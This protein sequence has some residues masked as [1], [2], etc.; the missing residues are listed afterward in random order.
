MGIITSAIQDIGEA[1]K[2]ATKQTLKNQAAAEIAKKDNTPKVRA[3]TGI[4]PV[5]FDDPERNDL[6]TI[7][8]A[9]LFDLIHGVLTYWAR[10]DNP[11]DPVITTLWVA[12]QYLAETDGP[13]LFGAHP[14]LMM[15]APPGS[16]KTR[17]MKLVRAMSKNPTGIVKAP[18]T[19]PGLRDALEA[20]RTVFLDEIDRQFGRGG[21]HLDIQSLV[22]AYEK[23]TGSLNGRGGYNEQAVFGPMMLAAKPRILTST[24]GYLEDLFERAFILTPVKHT[25]PDDPIPDLNAE[26]ESIVDPIPKVLQ[27]WGEAVSREGDLIDPIH[28][29]PKA[30]TSRMREIS[31]PLLAAADRGVD[32]DVIERQGQDLRWAVRGREAV[33][34]SLLG[35]G[36]NGNEILT[37]TVKR[38]KALGVKI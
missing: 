4:T 38:M 31:L 25:N 36:S 12:S 2:A 34:A 28:S 3:V 15:I 24:G 10:W 32:P 19:A 16:G 20:H 29:V 27:M 23:D 14:R 7:N 8:A 35:H 13:M 18:V 9:K 26:F 21:A 17:V 33:Q 6:P 1:G 11:H 30:L 22:S 5:Q 37:D